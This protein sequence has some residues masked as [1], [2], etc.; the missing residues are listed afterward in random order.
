MKTERDGTTVD[1]GCGVIYKG[2]KGGGM[3]WHQR[4]YCNLK[5]KKLLKAPCMGFSKTTNAAVARLSFGVTEK[6][7]KCPPVNFY[8]NEP[9]DGTIACL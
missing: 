5:L 3:T 6:W 1:N 4:I 8:V 2:I 7:R 9:G